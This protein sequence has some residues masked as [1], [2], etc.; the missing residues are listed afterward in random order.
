MPLDVPDGRAQQTTSWPSVVVP[1]RI[2]VHVK[3]SGTRTFRNPTHISEHMKRVRGAP[4]IKSSEAAEEWIPILKAESETLLNAVSDTKS[5]FQLDVSADADAATFQG[6]LTPAVKKAL[7]PRLSQLASSYYDEAALS[8]IGENADLY[9][10]LS[11][12]GYDLLTSPSRA[13]KL[14]LLP[15][16]C[17]SSYCEV[18]GRLEFTMDPQRPVKLA[19]YAGHDFPGGFDGG[20]QLANVARFENEKQNACVFAFR[21]KSSLAGLS[22]RLQRVVDAALK[23]VESTFASQF[24]RETFAVSVGQIHLVFGFNSHAHF[25]YH[26]DASEYTWTITVQLSPG[27]STIH[28]A[29]APEDCLFESPGDA[30]LFPAQ[31]YHRSGTKER[32]TLTMSIFFKIVRSRTPEAGTS[33]EGA[34]VTSKNGADR[35]Q[36]QPA[37]GVVE[38]SEQGTGEPA[39]AEQKAK[40]QDQHPPPPL[41]GDKAEG[42]SPEVPDAKVEKEKTDDES[43]D[44]AESAASNASPVVRASGRPPRKVRK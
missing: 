36:E 14:Q 17:M 7:H 11:Q 44:N 43:A 8:T 6:D 16:D 26:Q 27:A 1:T 18:I 33:A 13:L 10:S 38:K 40:E 2:G 28:I 5:W 23:H 41:G 34:V 42:Q 32:R 31:A 20:Y 24:E 37:S 4:T 22:K 3:H 9:E 25:L 35:S 39:S 30:F 15:D 29:G 19:G 12:K 21:N